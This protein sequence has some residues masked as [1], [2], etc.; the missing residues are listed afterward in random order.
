M[1]PLISSLLS[2]VNSRLEAWDLNLAGANNYH[3]E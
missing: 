1:A 3:A 2:A